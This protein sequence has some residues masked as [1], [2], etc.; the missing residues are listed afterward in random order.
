MDL[1][2]IVLLQLF[3]KS[4]LRDRTK[5]FQEPFFLF[6]VKF[7]KLGFTGPLRPILNLNAK[8]KKIHLNKKR[9]S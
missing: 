9:F 8:F 7:K 1:K 2:N 6:L 3:S 4:E 5:T